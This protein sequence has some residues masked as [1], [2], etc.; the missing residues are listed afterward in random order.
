LIK[1]GFALM[2]TGGDV[3]PGNAHPDTAVGVGLGVGVVVGRTVGVAVGDGCT[4]GFVVG[5]VVGVGVGLALG[6]GVGLADGD[7][8]GLGFMV[9]VGVGE[10]EQSGCGVGVDFHCG[11]RSVLAAA[12]RHAATLTSTF[13]TGFDDAPSE[14]SVTEMTH[15]PGASDV[16][17]NVIAPCD[18]F[19]RLGLTL[20]TAFELAAPAQNSLWYWESSSRASNVFFDC[21]LEN[22]KLAGE[23]VR[24]AFFVFHNVVTVGAVVLCGAAG[25]ATTFEA[26]RDVDEVG[27]VLPP[28]L[29]A[30][31]SAAII[32]APT[33]RKRYITILRETRETEKAAFT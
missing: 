30:A 15:D 9:G 28:P 1:I 25:T 13:A 10:G 24:S 21:T 22:V 8:V 32:A 31:T 11:S 6:A 17:V 5:V 33:S 19:A 18:D 12:V 26:R 7:A 3:D 23:T 2:R 16:T 29:Q 20:H 4:V 14:R 27:R